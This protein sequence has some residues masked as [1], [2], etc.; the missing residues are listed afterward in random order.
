MALRAGID[1]VEHGIDLDD[2]AIALMR[3][4]E[5]WLS[6][7][8]KCTEV[9]GVNRPEDAVPPY[10]AA[11]AG[12]IY[13]KQ[14]ASFCRARGAGV[15][16]SAGSDGMLSYFPLSAHTLIRE[17]AFMTELGL[18]P[19]EAISVATQSTAELLGLGDAGVIGPGKRADLFVVDGDPLGDLM[20]L[21]K[22]WLVMLGGRIVRAP[23]ATARAECVGWMM[24]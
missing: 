10:I 21:G 12:T 15:P 18:S 22:P 20:Q 5:V 23:E 7:C 13:Q 19:G 24:P 9:E 2:E 6:A 4:R 8:L 11:R 3:E 16:V 14:M 1:C 17:M